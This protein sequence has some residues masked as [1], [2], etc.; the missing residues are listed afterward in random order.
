MNHYGKKI[1]D[2]NEKE[3]ELLLIDVMLV[4]TF[5]RM[6]VDDVPFK[7]QLSSIRMGGHLSEMRMEKCK[8]LM[9]E[10]T[11]EEVEDSVYSFMGFL[12]DKR[13]NTKIF[14]DEEVEKE[15]YNFNWN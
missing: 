2:L 7:E 10:V 1:Q 13:S 12:K 9:G 8:E 3:T 15:E 5:E 11:Q 4:K 6:V 14:K